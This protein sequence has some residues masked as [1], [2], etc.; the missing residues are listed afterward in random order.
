MRI[1][2]FRKRN[3]FEAGFSLIE[4]LIA[5]VVFTIIMTAIW[6]LL[7]IGN[8]S[9]NKVNDR[10]ETIKNARVSVNS[11]GRD[12]VN[13]GLGFSRVGGL[14]PDDFAAK[15]LDIKKDGGN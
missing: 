10:S 6:G 4:M 3:Y 8:V 1:M 5:M 2:S 13:A 11:I 15:H 9:R 7:R 14:V 12:I